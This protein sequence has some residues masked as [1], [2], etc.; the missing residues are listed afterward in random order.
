MKFFS[1]S[2]VIFLRSLR[3]ISRSP[4]VILMTIIQPVLWMVLFG[5]VFSS[6]ADI[7]GFGGDAYM[8]FLGPGIVMMST[9]MAG[10]YAGMG[11]ISDYRDG[12]L[13]RL[14]ISPIKRSAI[15]WGSLLQDSLTLAFQAIMMIGIAVLMGAHFSGGLL[16]ITQF[17]IISILLG[18]TMGVLSTSL[19]L[20]ILKE[21]S[22]TAAVSFITMPLLFLSSLFIPLALVPNWVAT[23]AAFNPLHWAIEAGREVIT[24]QTDWVIVFQNSLYLLLLLFVSFILVIAAFKRYQRIV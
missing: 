15:L 19:G 1:D 8:D 22:L 10:A 12:V 5:Q 17:V 6:M 11:I 7:P 20:L 16:G 9:M 2:Y 21:S 13:D 23:I 14:M 4:F 24:H 3:S 18:L